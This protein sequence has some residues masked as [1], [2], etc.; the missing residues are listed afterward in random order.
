M[1]WLGLALIVAAAAMVGFSGGAA[2]PLWSGAFIALFALTAL[3]VAARRPFVEGRAR[4]VDASTLTRGRVSSP[5][6]RVHFVP[7]RRPGIVTLLLCVLWALVLMAATVVA[8]RIGLTGRPEA[9]LGVAVLAATAAL[10][11][12]AA[13]RAG[14]TQYRSDSFGRRPIG[15]GMGPDGVLLMRA[16]E[17]LY[18]PWSAIRRV[19]PDLTEQRRGMDGLPLIRLRVD[20]RRV[21]ASDGMRAP[22]TVTVAPAMLKTHP[23]V[24]WS[25]LRGFHDSPSTRA[26]LGTPT[27]QRLFDE[28]CA[29]APAD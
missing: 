11:A 10:F 13:V 27:G 17:T 7:E 22:E 1:L 29:S 19:E 6:A 21:T 2:G 16:T 23:Q 12:Y 28:W 20:P 15:L 8:I 26:A 9:F 4:P 5:D 25:A 14:I 3:A 18:V 24:V